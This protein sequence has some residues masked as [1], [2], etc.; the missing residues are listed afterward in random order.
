MSDKLAA[1][2]HGVACKG[3]CCKNPHGVCHHGHA[4]DYHSGAGRVRDERLY[5]PAYTY[6]G[7]HRQGVIQ[8]GRAA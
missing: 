5:E 1:V 8:D 4:C 2:Y 6:Q 7:V 3:E